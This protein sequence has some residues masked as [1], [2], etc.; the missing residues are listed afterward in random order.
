MEHWMKWEE[1]K[2]G[3]ATQWIGSLENGKFKAHLHKFSALSKISQGSIL[4]AITDP[5]LQ[6]IGIDDAADRKLILDNIA[7][8]KSR[9]AMM[10]K[11][12]DKFRVRS[13][14]ER[15]GSM[16]MSAVGRSG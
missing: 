14:K 7:L 2:L 8:L 15:R 6:I 10:K 3:D 16:S 11:S 13:K 9:T 12:R 5:T 1:W 4:N